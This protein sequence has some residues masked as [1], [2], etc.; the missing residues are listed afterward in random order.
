M[1][2]NVCPDNIFRMAEPFTT[3]LDMVMHHYEPDRLPKRLVCLLQGQG[4]SEGLYN[5]NMTF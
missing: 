4:H 3:K 1:S 5:K 2:M